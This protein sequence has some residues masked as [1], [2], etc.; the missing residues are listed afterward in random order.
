MKRLFEL[1]K[2]T[3]YSGWFKQRYRAKGNISA[4]L[5]SQMEQ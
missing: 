5:H 4:Y 3:Y 1:G 2:S